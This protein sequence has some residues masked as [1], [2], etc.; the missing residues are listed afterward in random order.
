MAKILLANQR[1]MIYNFNQRN[2]IC[3][4]VFATPQFSRVT[5]NAF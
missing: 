3:T 1:E 5:Q 4:K 2:R